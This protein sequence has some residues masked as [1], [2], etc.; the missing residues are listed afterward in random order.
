MEL[1]SYTV[2]TVGDGN[3]TSASHTHPPDTLAVAANS[4]ARCWQ[5]G[6][7]VCKSLE[8]YR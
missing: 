7:E 5:K 3:P 1:T 8:I 6:A 4:I 2:V